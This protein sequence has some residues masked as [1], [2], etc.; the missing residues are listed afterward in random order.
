MSICVVDPVLRIVSC[1]KNF[2]A[3]FG[4]PSGKTCHQAY[5]NQDTPCES[6]AVQKTFRDGV[7]RIS[8]ETGVDCIGKRADYVVHHSPIGDAS[9]RVRFIVNMSYDITDRKV[10]LTQYNVVFDR[11]PCSLSV[12]NRD[13]R[14]LRANE[15]ARARFG[16]AVGARCFQAYKRREAPCQ[17]CPA[18]RT[19][20]DGRVHT[21]QEVRMTADGV[22]TYHLT[23][24]APIAED[25]RGVSQIVEMSL[26]V[27]QVHELSEELERQR[28]TRH[29]ITESSLDA[30]VAVDAQGV[31]T[32]YNAAAESLFGLAREEVVQR[33]VAE[34]LLPR[35][36]LRAIRAGERSVLLKDAHVVTKTGEVVPVRL[37]G[38]VLRSGGQVVGGAAFL[39]DL[40]EIQELERHTLRNERMAT[41]GQTVT[42]LAHSI[43]N[44]LT[45]IQGGIYDIK[46]GCLRK[47][48]Q[49]RD[50]GLETLD[51]NF[52]RIDCMV[53]D[54]LRLSKDHKLDIEPCDANEVACEVYKLFRPLAE[55]RGITLSFEPCAATP[56]AHVDPEAVHTC[57][58]NLVSNALEACLNRGNACCQVRISVQSSGDTVAYAVQDTGCGM[59]DETKAKLF[60][61]IFTTK[62][63]C[64][65]G[66]GLMMTKKIVEDHGGQVL[67]SAR[68]GEGSRFTVVLPLG[69][70]HSA[71]G[72]G[73]QDAAASV[74]KEAK[75]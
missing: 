23:S 35:A 7:S 30:L 21:S 73:E 48:T 64:G 2:S 46:K 37:S 24:T 6:C 65:T 14:I 54:L 15:Q 4:D 12:I 33:Q 28:A 52:H 57:L 62:G 1:N 67:V 26:D 69:S 68:A 20:A 8:E 32:I 53:R 29:D 3:V 70:L 66:L 9:G 16:D 27:T 42:Q 38:T 44:I 25:R 18:R 58:S 11:V 17:E 43:K 39:Q 47:D 59:D 61:T 49:R 74:A 41:V 51:R 5:K 31:V 36:F 22:C 55:R 72:D 50:E 63:S 10:F 60:H 34:R 45:G 19:F 71:S 13:L 75:T 40:R 56:V